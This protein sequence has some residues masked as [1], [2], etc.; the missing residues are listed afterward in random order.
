[1]EQVDQNGEKGRE[2]RRGGEGAEERHTSPSFWG[3][4]NKENPTSVHK[5]KIKEETYNR[6]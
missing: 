1:M 3:R 5:E 4:K 2:R 6:F